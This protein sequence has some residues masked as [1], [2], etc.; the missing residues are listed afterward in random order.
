M[1]NKSNNMN[2]TVVAY[3][4]ICISHH[5]AGFGMYQLGEANGEAW[6]YLS[7]LEKEMDHN[8][9]CMLPLEEALQDD[10]FVAAG[11]EDIRGKIYGGDPTYIYAN[12]SDGAITY[13]GIEEQAIAK[14]YWD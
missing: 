1:G 8:L 4:E 14:D 3:R 5:H 7:D 9:D 6:A 12:L 2:D 13:Y 10:E 11:I